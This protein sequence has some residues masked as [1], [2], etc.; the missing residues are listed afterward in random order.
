VIKEKATK[1]D[2]I[3]F[4]SYNSWRNDAQAALIHALLELGK[5]VILFVVRDPIDAAL[6]PK[7]D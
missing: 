2:A 4:C 5:P 3:I 6:Y 1:S 7:A